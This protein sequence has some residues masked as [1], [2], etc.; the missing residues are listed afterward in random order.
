MRLHASL[1]LALL[2]ASPPAA[3]QAPAESNGWYLGAGVEA[4]RFGHVVVSDPSE[5][6]PAELRPSGRLALRLRVARSMGPWVAALE[7]GW[8]DGHAEARNDV[9]AITDRTSDVTRYRV[10]VAVARRV[11]TAGSG[12]LAVELAP[13]ADLWE[14]AGENRVRAGAEARLVLLVPL[15]GV[16]LEHRIGVGL[17]GSPIEAAEVGA[18]AEERSL[19]TLSVGLGLR[20][21]L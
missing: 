3:A 12:V 18:D 8:A 16:Q 6:D 10:S 13:T 17:S 1:L 15:G 11:A 19:R 4:L 7:A 9:V 14:V 20:T 21:R 5:E 2:A